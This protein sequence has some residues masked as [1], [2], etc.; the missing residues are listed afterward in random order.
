MP[1][2]LFSVGGPVDA[3]V[4]RLN[5]QHR[6]NVDAVLQEALWAGG[7]DSDSHSGDTLQVQTQQLANVTMWWLHSLSGPLL[8]REQQRAA[9]VRAAQPAGEHVKI[10]CGWLAGY[11]ISCC[12]A[13]TC[14]LCGCGCYL[15]TH[16]ALRL[17]PQACVD[18]KE[19]WWFLPQQ[20]SDLL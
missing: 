16:V 12:L 5:R 19:A 14:G 10:P 18:N 1:W 20:L 6:L 3:I 11:I 4:Q 7:P 17:R 9:Q 15:T 8:S 13:T 2:C